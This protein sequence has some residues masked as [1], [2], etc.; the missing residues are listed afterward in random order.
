MDL[1]RITEN[2]IEYAA[3]I[4]AFALSK[5][6]QGNFRNAH[7]N[8]DLAEGEY[9][10]TASPMPGMPIWSSALRPFLCSVC[11]SLTGREVFRKR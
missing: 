3:R 7:W 9:M 8:R 2:N 11:T 10:R 1:E 6:P 4:G 5:T